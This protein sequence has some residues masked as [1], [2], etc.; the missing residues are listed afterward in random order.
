M[1]VQAY[2]F[3]P[4]ATGVITRMH[5]SVACFRSPQCVGDLS[6]AVQKAPPPSVVAVCALLWGYCRGFE[7]TY[8]CQQLSGA[9]LCMHASLGIHLSVLWRLLGHEAGAFLVLVAGKFPSRL[10]LF[11]LLTAVCER[12]CLFPYTFG[13]IG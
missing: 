10:H 1:C 3:F 13:N 7:V 2:I 4:W 11:Q 6:L 12:K 9:H 5:P 8:C